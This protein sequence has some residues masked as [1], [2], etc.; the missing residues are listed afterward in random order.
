MRSL[1]KTD[2]S[3]RHQFAADLLMEN[4]TGQMHRNRQSWNQQ[5]LKMIVRSG[6]VRSGH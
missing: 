6:N 4:E 2:F 3:L 5:G 1:F